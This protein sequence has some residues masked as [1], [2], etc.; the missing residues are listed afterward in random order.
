MHIL[1]KIPALSISLLVLACGSLAQANTLDFTSFAKNIGTNSAISITTTGAALSGSASLLGSVVNLKSFEWNFTSGDGFP[2]NDYSFLG[3]LTNP[4]ITLADISGTGDAPA[5]TGWQTYVFSR[6]YSGAISFGVANDIDEN[7][8]SF[9]AL[10][11]LTTLAPVPEPE[12]YLL[13]L[14]GLGLL[15]AVAR[16]RSN[17]L[18]AAGRAAL[19]TT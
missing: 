6:S 3:L 13:H 8:P 14:S 5:S 16:R 18:K 11:N 2:F 12:T 4:V 10:R 1:K 17:R 15:G 7:N 19:A 9:L